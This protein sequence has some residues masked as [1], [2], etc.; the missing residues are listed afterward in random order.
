MTSQNANSGISTTPSEPHFL[1]KF[2]RIV[3][4]LWRFKAPPDLLQFVLLIVVKFKYCVSNSRVVVFR[5]SK[6]RS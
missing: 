2:E 5:L 6:I 1:A 3:S 4:I